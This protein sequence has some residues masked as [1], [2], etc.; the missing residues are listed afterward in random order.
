MKTALMF[1]WIESHYNSI[2]SSAVLMIILSVPAV[3]GLVYL[4]GGPNVYT[5]SMYVPILIGSLVFGM[6][7][8]I[9]VGVIAGATLGPFMPLDTVTME[10]QTA[11][12]WLYRSGFFVIMGILCG[13]FSDSIQRYLKHLKWFTLHDTDTGLPDR[14]ALMNDLKILK[15]TGKGAGPKAL[16]VVS[17]ENALELEVTFGPDVTGGIIKQMASDIV[18]LLGDKTEVYR[19]STYLLAALLFTEERDDN[20]TVRARLMDK[21]RSPV[22]YKDISLHADIRAGYTDL[23]KSNQEPIRYLQEAEAALRSACERAH[24]WAIYTPELNHGA[25]RENLELLGE[26]KEAVDRKQLALHY[27]PKVSFNSGAVL[28]VEAL[29]RWTHPKLGNVP[30]G[31]FIPRAEQSTLIDMLTEW[32][33]DTALAQL[34]EW[35]KSGIVLSVAVNISTRNLLEPNF[36]ARVLKQLDNY[37]VNGGSLE[38]EVTEWALMKDIRHSFANIS[39]LSKA[40][41]IFSIDDF[42]TGYASLEYL[43]DFPASS[44]K[45][46]QIF[47]REIWDRKRPELI[48]ESSV[49][50]AHLLEIKAVAEGVEDIASYK[51]LCDLGCDVAQGY[52][53]S[54]P[55][56]APEFA[57]WYKKSGG[58]FKTEDRS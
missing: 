17:I 45:I 6:R 15:S 57:E 16:V 42:G 55:V 12:S 41:V 23:S 26:L 36:A 1:K 50:M 44:I 58:I 3:Y 30:P 34:V 25:A 40:G 21:F 13:A 48:V 4:T 38:L 49:N 51:L 56:P 32:A 9:V 43:K 27:Q 2:K 46:D 39:K 19:I 5:H 22:S 54:R 33:I 14:S 28:G 31:K 29:M 47:I 11:V 37:K 52:F 8:G 10:P 18:E 24:T 53:I 20:R 7:G 35:K